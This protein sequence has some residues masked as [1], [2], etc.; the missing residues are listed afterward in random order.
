MVS[1]ALSVLNRAQFAGLDFDTSFDDSLARIQ[2]QFASSFN[3][4]ALSS[5]GI[6][7]IDLNSY[8]ID[9]LSFYLDRRATDTYLQTARTRGAVSR[10]TRQLG[11]KMGAAIASS[12]DLTVALKAPV[13]FPVLIPKGFQ[14]QG[15][16]GLIFE[17]AKP[18]TYTAFSGPNNPQKIPCYEGETVTELFTSD[19][20]ADQ[21]LTLARVPQNKS[22][23]AGTVVVTVNGTPWSEIDFL[24]PLP[25][26]QNQFEFA[27]NDDPPTVRFG[28]GVFGNIPTIGAT[29][30]VTYVA[31]SGRSG[32]VLKNTIQK[33]VN[34]LVVAFQ[35][36]Q[37]TIDN[38]APSVGGDD[39]ESLDHAKAFAPKV[40]KTRD[41][42]I[43]QEDFESL[44]GAFADPLFGRVAVAQAISSRSGATDLD[45]QSHL[46][47]IN[48]TVAIPGP[49]ISAQ[50]TAGQDN[51]ATITTEQTGISTD[52][53]NIATDM[54]VAANALSTAI[55]D[56]RAVK[57]DVGEIGVSAS[58]VSDVAA[59]T[60][61][62]LNVPATPPSISRLGTVTFS[63]AARTIQRGA[64]SWSAD[65]VVSGLK[66]K[67][68]GSA[69]NDGTYGIQSVTTT[70][71]SG[72]T[73]TLIP[74]TVLVNGTDN[75]VVASVDISDNDRL[76]TATKTTLRGNMDAI[77][78][79]ATTITTAQS[80]ALSSIDGEIT[81][82]NV[83]LTNINDVGQ[84]TT[85]P[86]TQLFFI[87]THLTNVGTAVTALSLN[88]TTILAAFTDETAVIADE[89]QAISDHVD[90]ILSSDCKA[91][92]VTVP[93][94]TKDAT[95]FF[96]APSI[97][98]VQALQT[99]LD[100]RKEVT[101]TVKV[102]SGAPFLVPAVITVRIGVLKNFGLSTVQAAASAA[103]D[104]IL[105]DRKFGQT[106]FESEVDD[107]VRGVSGV[108]F[109]NVTVNG[110]L[111]SDGVTV[112]AD[113][114]DATGNLLVTEGQ[115]ITKGLVTLNI[116]N[117][118]ATLTAET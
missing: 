9:T 3:D 99:F 85:T 10:L 47:T 90:Q 15:P 71:I 35:T 21:V 117:A 57:S 4:F 77:S 78:A 80:S 106:L 14:F 64:G 107:A 108:G 66:V 53:N 54:T 43:T 59:T 32:L 1:A 19:G 58:A 87:E 41:V 36:I 31:T 60:K 6:V 44:A 68:T 101:Q 5:L 49:I 65:G 94:L 82:M 33:P 56:A 113:K 7:L 13:A 72:D 23:A 24:T 79:S 73:L 18:I 62:A 55:A 111:A 29:V 86:G 118:P 97:S 83:A 25:A 89:T 20:T 42:S 69:S 17:S 34:P 102:T 95:G 16:N 27:A 114:L 22:I 45:L 67:I 8:S 40:F 105:R 115:I 12:V 81:N 37:L 98:L 104:S 84:N 2:V 91:N 61:T 74:G 103:I 51:L 76:S 93:I 46:L 100:S 112:L 52:A 116:E 70:S 63:A 38:A 88:F 75:N 50:V 109:W 110:Y 11:Y 96:A 92:L 26:D 39:P 30:Q 48:N 28:D